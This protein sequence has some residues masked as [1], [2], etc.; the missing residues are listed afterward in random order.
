[1]GRGIGRNK[2]I[3]GQRAQLSYSSKGKQQEH[4]D[5]NY[6]SKT[7]ALLGHVIHLKE[8]VPAR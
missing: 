6:K 5:K 7:S 2:R 8:I 1:L 4:R 3:I